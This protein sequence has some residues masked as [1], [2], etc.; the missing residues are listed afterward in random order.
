MKLGG[1]S[2]ALKDVVFKR[3][4]QKFKKVAKYWN[5]VKRVM[6]ALK[7]P[8]QVLDISSKVYSGVKGYNKYLQQ[9]KDF[10]KDNQYLGRV[11]GAVKATGDIIINTLLTKNPVVGIA[12]TVVDVVT[13]GRVQPVGQT[14]EYVEDLV[15][16]GSYAAMYKY[17]SHEAMK[18]V[19]RIPTQ[20]IKQMIDNLNDTDYVRDRGLSPEK[21]N[22][23]RQKY[24][25]MLT[26]A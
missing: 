26:E 25:S 3:K 2:K 21:V 12:D 14:V 1:L 24:T 17:H 9:N 23:L 22:T 6:K 7:K 8:L 4:I 11:L 13:G 20:R 10:V 18:N 16:K 19:T 5:K 15:D